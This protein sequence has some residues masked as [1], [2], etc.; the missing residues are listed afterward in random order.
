[1]KKAISFTLLFVGLV[2]MTY[3]QVG[4]KFP[5]MTCSKL[6]GK[7]EVVLPIPGTEKYT[8]VGLAFSKKSEEALKT[9]YK[10]IYDKFIA[11]STNK[12]MADAP[13]DVAMYFVPMFTGLN[14]AA[15]GSASKQMEEGVSPE[16][17]DHILIFKGKMNDYKDIL[18]LDKKDEPYF[19]VIDSTGKIVYA[20]SGAYVASKMGGIE[21]IV[22]E[23]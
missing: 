12:L 15:A 4:K 2:V 14:A 8:L 16:M 5:S 13:Y 19:F 17:K 20:T 3:A 18:G 1:M 22:D 6:N 10:P 7:G 11:K 9:W 23:F 21:D